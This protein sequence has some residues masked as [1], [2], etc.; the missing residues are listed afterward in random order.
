MNENEDG[1][2][3]GEEMKCQVLFRVGAVLDNRKNTT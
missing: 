2:V 3:G 1:L